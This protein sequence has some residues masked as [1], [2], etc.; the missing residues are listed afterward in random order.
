MKQI[1]L[2]VSFDDEKLT[3]LRHYMAKK[4]VSPEQE[5]TDALAKLYE[6][7][8]PA[9]VREYID[10]VDIK[11]PPAPK[12]KRPVK[13]VISKSEESEE[14]VDGSQGHHLMDQ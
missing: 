4:S 12:P 7:Y 1:N 5:L 8:V 9:P 10:D 11:Q 13:S 6:K 2:T 3:A 14:T